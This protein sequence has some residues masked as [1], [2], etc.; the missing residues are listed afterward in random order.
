VY[1]PE[2]DPRYFPLP[3]SDARRKS[4][5][6]S[7]GD[8]DSSDGEKEK[9]IEK[10]KPKPKEKLKEKEKEKEE[11]KQVT[12]A[13]PKQSKA[14]LKTAAPLTTPQVE[15]I[16]KKAVDRAE[17]TEKGKK[18]RGTKSGGGQTANKRKHD[19]EEGSFIDFPSRY[20]DRL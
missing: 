11:P 15:S 1:D 20:W 16:A 7:D 9:L 10:E 18:G 2:D 12:K 17:K 13:S 19:Q 6:D 14:S 5:A 3:K 4:F 8:F